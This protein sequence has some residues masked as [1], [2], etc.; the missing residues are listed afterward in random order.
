M[1]ER[2][3]TMDGH[4]Y[5]IDEP[6]MV[7]A[8]QNP[9]EYEGTFDLPEAQLDRFLMKIKIGYPEPEFELKILDK[10]DQQ[11]KAE[12]LLP[13][14]TSEEVL[15]MRQ[16]V[17]K[18]HVSKPLEEYIFE[19]IRQTRNHNEVLLGCSPRAAIALYKAVKAKAFIENRDFV[20][21]EDIQSL[22]VDILS[23]RVILK[24]E[25]KYKGQTSEQK[26]L[27]VIKDIHAPSVRS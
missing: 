20:I 18:V 7:I 24:P 26:I 12:D 2:Q 3:V 11:L 13:V 23:H 21:P 6:F 1:E 10:I 17:A 15:N 19:I 25:N 14:L 4:T 8:T 9:I 22:A 27:D 5:K 16:S